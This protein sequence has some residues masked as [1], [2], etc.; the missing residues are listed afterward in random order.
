MIVQ[1]RNLKRERRKEMKLLKNRWFILAVASI[2]NFVHGNPYIW[3]VFQPC[4][5]EEYGLTT[6]A[7]SQPFTII[8]GI[9]AAGNMLGGYLQHR[10]GAR[11]TIFWGSFVMCAGFF[12]AAMAPLHMPWLIDLGYGALG[13]LGS[14]CAFSML[15][16]VPQAWFPERRGMVSGLTIGMV[17]ISGILM[18]PLC[19]W[20]LSSFGYRTAMLCVTAIYAV[21]SLGGLLVTE[22]PKQRAPHIREQSR[23]QYTPGQMM[24]TRTFYVISLTMALAVPAYV[25][26]NPVMKSLGMERGLTSGQALAAVMAASVANII[27][28][29]ALPWLSDRT[30]RRKVLFALYLLSAISVLGLTRASGLLFSLLASAVCLVYGGVVSL[31]PVVVSDH[32]GTRHQGTNYGAVMIGYG[33]A[34]ILCPFL[35]NLAGQ[36]LSLVIAGAASAAGLL[37]LRFF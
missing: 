15:T 5:K 25:L 24:R 37:L 16:A 19:D 34:S 9:F 12:L 20:L 3:T 8:I 29:F 13:G 14:G 31:F 17:G 26:V 28:R 22:P 35:L 6:A 7:S 10:I 2:V 27:G 11:N 1:K 4:V 30:G 18:N 23:R 36:E 32:F 33:L 21:L